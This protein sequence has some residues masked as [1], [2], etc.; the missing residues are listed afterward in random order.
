MSKYLLENNE[1]GEQVENKLQANEAKIQAGSWSRA[2]EAALCFQGQ[3]AGRGNQRQTWR[4]AQWVIPISKDKGLS[5]I[6]GS[7]GLTLT[8]SGGAWPPYWGV[9]LW[10]CLRPPV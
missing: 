10:P 8:E 3:G 4:K 5:L 9:Q 6:P 7:L 1:L 2:W